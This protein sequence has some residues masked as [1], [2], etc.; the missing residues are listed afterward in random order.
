[1]RA[2][3][4]TACTLVVWASSLSAANVSKSYSYFPI[5]GITLGELERE[6]SLLGPQVQSTGRR[7]AGAAQLQFTTQLTYGENKGYCRIT[8]AAVTV[9]VNIILPRWTQRGL[10][11]KAVRNFWDT[12]LRDIKRHE[13]AHVVIARNHASEIE[14]TLKRLGR[15]RSCEALAQRAAAVTNKI[16]ERHDRKQIE[17]DRIE[18]INYGTRISNLL[19]Y[20]LEQIEAGRLPD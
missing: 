15:G 16:L 7:H 19:R 18:G 20:R 14:Q 2:I 6:L 4:L 13:E 11:D 3:L 17:F 1:M 5:G 8:E 9:K 10:A 12:L